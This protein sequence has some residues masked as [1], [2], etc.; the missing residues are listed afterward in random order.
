MQKHVR[1][2]LAAIKAVAHAAGCQATHVGAT[3]SDH[4]KIELRRGQRF[5]GYIPV[6]CS[7]KNRDACVDA[8]RRRARQLVRTT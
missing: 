5:L 1:E 8:C 7:P 3:T 6:A 2:A 4:I